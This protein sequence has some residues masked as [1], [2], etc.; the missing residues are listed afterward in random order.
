MQFLSGDLAV[1]KAG[2]FERVS[3]KE[4]FARRA[5]HNDKK[6]TNAR[7]GLNRLPTGDAQ[8]MPEQEHAQFSHD[9]LQ[10]LESRGER[11]RRRR[12]ASQE[13]GYQAA[14]HSGGLREGIG[15]DG[16]GLFF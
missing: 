9:M 1:K 2:Q 8:A 6:G 15:S 14:R 10:G 11:L 13:A 4:G 12:Q 3:V 5:S 7:G 16:L